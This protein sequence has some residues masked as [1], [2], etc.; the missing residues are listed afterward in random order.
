MAVSIKDIA[1]EANVSPS[2]VSR[3][4]NNHPRISDKTKKQIQT[5][6]KEME[7]VPSSI[8][9]DLVG[10]HSATIGVAISDF[11]NPFY[12]DIVA[13]IEDVAVAN[14]Y[15]V[16]VSSFYRDKQRELELF[17]IFYERRFAG[18]I[19]S[20]SLV[21]N[22]YLSLP[23]NDSMP[24]VLIN[25][26]SYTFSVS[27][28]KVLGARLAVEYLVEL[29]H[30]R[31]AFIRQGFDSESGRLRLNSFRETLNGYGITVDE[32]YIMAG[33]EWF[34]GGVRAVAQ[35][36]ALAKP[37]TAVFCFNDM[38]A[39]GVINAL[40]QK[41]YKVPQDLSVIGFDD[42]DIAYFYHPSLTTVRQ[43][44][45]QI[46][47]SAAKMLYS[48]IQCQENIQAQVLEPELIIRESTAPPN[49]SI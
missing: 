17:N 45:Y 36:L 11:L 15:Q 13:S 44:I 5:L 23:H 25:C 30:R 34:T 35:L 39:I 19:V 14:N 46:G 10:Q 2:T 29:G 24:V 12:S 32:R 1:K 26:P 8:A 18:I 38:T 42:L 28:D 3:A 6:A 48:L 7:Y 20:G 43:P 31:I 33:D 22:E 40:Q 4:L 27:T 9:R 41:G 49:S 21:D 16:F 37:P 47:R